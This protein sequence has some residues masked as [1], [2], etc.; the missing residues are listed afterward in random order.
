MIL[1][2]KSVSVYFGLGPFRIIFFGCAGATNRFSVATLRSARVERRREPE[3]THDN[4]SVSLKKLAGAQAVSGLF[5][6]VRGVDK[7]FS[8][9]LAY[10]PAAR[11]RQGHRREP[12]HTL[13][14]WL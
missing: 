3:N 13:Q 4:R 10:V 6:S 2:S 11:T 8:A 12:A 5:S 9:V 1:V 7:R 14:S